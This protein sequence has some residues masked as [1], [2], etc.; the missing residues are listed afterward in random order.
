MGNMRG[1]SHATGRVEAGSHEQE[2]ERMHVRVCMRVCVCVCVC[3]CVCDPHDYE[4]K[5]GAGGVT[6]MYL[7]HNCVT[8]SLY[9]TKLSNRHDACPNSKPSPW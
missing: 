3:A 6:E 5:P 8:V 1:P 7:A 2:Q 9:K 4:D